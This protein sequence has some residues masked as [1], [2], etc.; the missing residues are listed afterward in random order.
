MPY[1]SAAEQDIGLIDAVNR[2]VCRHL[3]T[4]DMAV[5]SNAEAF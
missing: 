1:G 2:S 3:A 4:D 5:P